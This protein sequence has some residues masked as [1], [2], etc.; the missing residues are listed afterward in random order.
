MAAVTSMV[1]QVLRD[2]EPRLP[3]VGPS[4]AGWLFQVTPVSDHVVLV[5]NRSVPPFG[6]PPLPM[7]STWMRSLA[8]ATGSVR[9][10]TVN[11]RKVRRTGELSTM[12]WDA[13]PK[14][15]DGDVFCTY[16]SATGVN[17]K[18]AANAA[19][20]ANTAAAVTVVV[21]TAITIAAREARDI[22][23]AP[24]CRTAVNLASQPLADATH[25]RRRRGPRRRPTRRAAPR[26]RPDAARRPYRAR[27]CSGHCRARGP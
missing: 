16:A 8:L 26:G 5:M 14:F 7:S 20:A 17:V 27:G 21:T 19:G 13:V 23:A 10:P 24:L 3:R 12:I 4:I 25:R 9:P 1:Y 11:R 2:T 18:V 6:L 22:R 15:V